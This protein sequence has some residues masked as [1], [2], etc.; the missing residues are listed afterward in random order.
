MNN[1]PQ[2]PS[3]KYLLIDSKYRYDTD[4]TTSNF[5]YYLPYPIK[6]KNKIQINYLY[7][8]RA[9]YLFDNSNNIIDIQF[10]EVIKTN[11]YDTTTI[12]VTIPIQN[13]TP[14]QLAT[15][16]TNYIANAYNFLCV[17]NDSTYKFEFSCKSGVYIALD[18]TKSNINRLFSMNKDIY[19]NNTNKY[20]TNVINFN[21]PQYIN[22]NIVNISNDVMMGNNNCNSFNF[23]IPCAG[24]TNFGSIIEYN[25]INY[26]VSM[27]VN[28]ITLN[29]LDIQITDDFN[30]IYNNNNLDFFAILEYI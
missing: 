15:F 14:T 1:P 21:N 26:N 23:I 30:Q 24:K 11:V 22:F 19:T 7:M 25:N 6:I 27:P 5:R 12:R 29:Y 18:L 13:Y 9:N 2:V 28:D 20:I 3:A 17:Y 10:K 16:I 4:Q 8:P